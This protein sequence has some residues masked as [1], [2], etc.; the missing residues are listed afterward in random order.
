M[1]DFST[2]KEMAPYLEQP[3]A[4]YVGAP[5][6]TGYLF[7]GFELAGHTVAVLTGRSSNNTFSHF[8]ILLK[9]YIY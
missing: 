6:K 3:K 7:M 8:C 9:I 4:M 5:G 2:A 1:V